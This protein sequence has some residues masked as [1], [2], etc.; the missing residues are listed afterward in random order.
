MHSSFLGQ[1]A[2]QLLEKFGNDLR[3]ICIVMPNKR[4]AQ[5]LYKELS[6]RNN[7]QAIWAPQV[8]TS[9]QLLKEYSPLVIA[10]RLI[11][12]HELYKIHSRITQKSEPLHKF[13]PWGEMLLADFNDI[14][15]YRVPARLLY[16]NLAA[17]KE[18]LLD[19]SYLSEK[20]LEAIRLFWGVFAADEDRARSDFSEIWKNLFPIY[21]SFKKRLLELNIGYEGM[22]Y[23]D[24]ADSLVKNWKKNEFQEYVFVGFNQLDAC[25]RE[26][27]DTIISNETHQFYW[28]YDQHYSHNPKHEA[29][30]FARK[31]E[32]YKS[33]DN[34]PNAL[35]E[36]QTEVYFLGTPVESG[37]AQWMGKI[38]QELQ[39]DPNKTGIILPREDVLS[40]VLTALPPQYEKVNVTMGHPIFNSS[41]YP[42]VESMYRLKDRS[43]SDKDVKWY[44]VPLLLKV[45]Q[46]PYIQSIIPSEK[47]N[48]IENWKRRMYIKRSDILQDFPEF[49]Y[50]L[51]TNH[52][53][54]KFYEDF[55][56]VLVQLQNQENSEL[57]I[58]DRQIIPIVYK[59]LNRLYELI[60]H[61]AFSDTPD[62]QI[63]IIQST[64]RTLKVPFLGEPVDG[65]Q[66]MGPLESRS[67]DFDYVFIPSMNEG[68]FPGSSNDSTYIPQSLR[69]AFGMPC[70]DE[71]MAA[72]A[73]FFYRLLHRAKKVFLFY[74]TEADGL[75]TG[76]KSRYLWQLMNELENLNIQEN[77]LS[78]RFVSGHSPLIT[79]QKNDEIIESL[80]SFTSKNEQI[81]T[82]SPTALSTYISCSLAFY[83]QKIARLSEEELN[84]DDIDARKFGNILHETL[85]HLYKPLIGKQLQESDIKSLKQ[86]LSKVLDSAFENQA[87]DNT[88]LAI[89]SEKIIIKELIREFALKVLNNDLKRVPFTVLATELG[90]DDDSKLLYQVPL[91]KYPY[92]VR[93]SGIVDRIDLKDGIIEIIDYKTGRVDLKMDTPE[94]LFDPELGPKKKAVLQTILYGE[95][96]K[97][98]K[99]Q[100]AK[101][102]PGIYA[103]AGTSTDE[104]I[105]VKPSTKKSV[106][107]EGKTKIVDA[108]LDENDILEVT[109]GLKNT[110]DILFN[111]DIPFEQTQILDNCR[112]CD[113]KGIC[114]RN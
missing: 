47:K 63:K 95:M 79:V 70:A 52:D 87:S 13:F 31:N 81:R 22:V 113:F 35:R 51:F 93:F 24:A 90:A 73:Y 64:L 72:Q 21:E 101:T 102:S 69:K 74:N 71:K 11:L 99:D 39:L 58:I 3:N 77:S 65:L 15:K 66:I 86:T 100:N 16:S 10:D 109:E 55:L 8:K 26:L 68:S 67:L 114:N 23:R 56:S 96:Y 112:Y 46:N 34:V 49:E 30:L 19:Y 48:I 18:L 2:T 14:D 111:K 29:G 98:S 57:P 84:E 9:T 80:L 43:R 1:V 91:E 4:A 105:L 75:S 103:L 54:T 45:I 5:F 92:K 85:E 40:S 12:I 60:S 89:E 7:N 42:L 41:I 33:L 44:Y 78:N 27:F 6:I 106:S 94:L 36:A 97:E 25:E 83:F 32:K 88:G 104:N 82:I 37:Q 108:E 110:L 17:E 76:E 53:L 20:Q 61:E 107:E 62:D 50:T 59:E 28:D 38:M